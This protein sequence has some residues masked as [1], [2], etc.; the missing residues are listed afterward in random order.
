MGLL[1]LAAMVINCGRSWFTRQCC[2]MMFGAMI[3]GTLSDKLGR[4]SWFVSPYLAD[5]PLSVPLTNW[6]CYFA[7]YCRSWYWWP[8]VVALMTEYA[9]KKIRSTQSCLVVMQLVVW[10]QHYSVRKRHGLANHVFNCG[11]SSFPLIWKFL[12][13]SLA[14][15]VKSANRRKVL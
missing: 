9:P 8:N 7:L 11:Y 13:E 3:F 14:F 12:P 15:L 1:F 2:C 4:P 5:L 6:V 10:H